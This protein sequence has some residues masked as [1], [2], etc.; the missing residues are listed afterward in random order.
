MA[1]MVVLTGVDGLPDLAIPATS[2]GVRCTEESASVTVIASATPGLIDG[3]VAR[4]AGSLVV[5]WGGPVVGSAALSGVRYDRGATGGS[6]TLAANGKFA[7]GSNKEYDYGHAVVPGTVSLRALYSVNG[8]TRWALHPGCAQFL[9]LI[10]DGE[11]N[12]LVA[13]GFTLGVPSTDVSGAAAGTIDYASGLV[14]LCA[15]MAYHAWWRFLLPPW[16]QDEYGNDIKWIWQMDMD[17][18]WPAR[19]RRITQWRD[20]GVEGI[21]YRYSSEGKRRI[22]CAIADIQPG[23]TVNLG[24]GETM[25]VT[26]VSYEIRPTRGEM[27]LSE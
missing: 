16:S 21:S 5:R 27:E 15:V 18:F 9:H 25:E 1:D 23:D 3:I 22:R 6:V 14:T 13:P 4:E 24:G 12:V 7:A 20:G 26:E 2:V 10:D 19:N 8:T 17:E 11:S